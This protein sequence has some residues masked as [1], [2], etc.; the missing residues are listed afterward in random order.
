VWRDIFYE[1]RCGPIEVPAG[2]YYMLGDNT[3]DSS[4]S[5]E[6]TF[7]VL[8][9]AGGDGPPRRVRGNWRDG[10][11]PRLVGHGEDDGPLTYLVDEWGEKHWFARGAAERAAPELAPF[12][13]RA[14]IQGKA[15]AVFWP[16]DPLR[17]IWR[18]KWVN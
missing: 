10:E 17:G 8:E 11:N 16:L 3:Q 1:T 15:L 12:V 5:R 6:W 4:D 2:S 7:V 18:R 9:T 14:L 13:P